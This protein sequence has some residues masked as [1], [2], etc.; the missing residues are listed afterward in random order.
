VKVDRDSN[1]ITIDSVGVY[2]FALSLND[3]IVDLDEEVTIVRNG[4]PY[5]AN[6]SRTVGTM[7]AHFEQAFDSGAVFPVLLRQLDVPQPPADAPA[8]GGGN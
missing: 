8:D 4:E 1:T 5:K 2:T 3:L 6:F 7:L